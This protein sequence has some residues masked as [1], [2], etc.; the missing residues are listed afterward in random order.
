MNTH[1]VVTRFN[2][3]VD[4]VQKINHPVTIYDKQ[5]CRINVGSEAWSDLS[6]IVDNYHDLP[7]RILCLH[8]NEKSYH[9]DY[10]GW[11]IANNLN[12]N[13]DYVNVNT[14][15]HGE[16]YFSRI[17][18]FEDNE[19]FYRKSFALWMVSSWHDMFGDDLVMPDTLTFIGY[20]QFLV[21]K[22]LIL[23]HPVNFYRRLLNWLETTN[24]D[25]EMY[26]GNPRL[27]NRAASYVSGRI[28]EYTWH[29]IFTGDPEEKV[30]D[31]LL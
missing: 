19:R 23:R 10:E 5:K 17:H 6:F 30:I 8:G 13:L 22:K 3:D 24:I 27:F 4:W 31:F 2:E 16:Q 20:S 28:L 15:R 18:D 25:R 1:V 11:Y 26:V 14:R 21:S 29:Y 9:Q 12:W 7:D